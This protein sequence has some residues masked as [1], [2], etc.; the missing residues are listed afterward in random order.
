MAIGLNVGLTEMGLVR[1]VAADLGVDGWQVRIRLRL[2]SP[3]CQYFFYFQQ[4]LENR[5]LAHHGMERVTVEWDGGIDWTPEDLALSARQKI[6]TRNRLLHLSRRRQEQT[7]GEDQ[8][9]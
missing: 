8:D 1:D 7:R 3:G 5:I 2:T 4:Q 6:E 9:R